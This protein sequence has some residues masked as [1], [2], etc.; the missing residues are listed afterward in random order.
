MIR[1]T[2]YILENIENLKKDIIDKVNA[3]TSDDNVKDEDIEKIL[4]KINKILSSSNIT[5][6]IINDVLDKTG[7]SVIKKTIIQKLDSYDALPDIINIK[8]DKKIQISSKD[9]IDND[10][11]YDL[12]NSKLTNKFDDD[13]LEDLSTLTVSI[14]SIT[15]GQYE[16]LSRLFLNDITD[17]NQKCSNGHYADI[18]TKGLGAIEYKVSGARAM[19]QGTISN[20][21]KVYDYLQ[22]ALIIELAKLQSSSTPKHNDDLETDLDA[23]LKE[24]DDKIKKDLTIDCKDAFQ[25]NDNISKLSEK[26]KE[27]KLSNELLNSIL[28]N[29]LLQQCVEKNGN[30]VKDIQKDFVNF[31]QK[32]EIIKNKSINS[33]DLKQAMLVL[34]LM[35]YR[36]VEEWDYMMV[37][38]K[39]K[40]TKGKYCMLEPNDFKSFETLN[41]ALQDKGIKNNTLPRATEISREWAPSIYYIKK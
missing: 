12:I 28:A 3:I 1:L 39:N 37:F 20:I 34:H 17:K 22:D 16:I 31:I 8:N 14:N 26:L 29:A 7:L 38:A 15:M 18:N 13:F 19:G 23:A 2:Q 9:L 30:K 21:N 36:T 33:N 41:K 11:I 35:W 10:N 4:K 32:E 40:S 24:L 5:S 27:T 25:T 6:D